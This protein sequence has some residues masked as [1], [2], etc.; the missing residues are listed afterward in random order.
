MLSSKLK[1]LILLLTAVFTLFVSTYQLAHAHTRLEIGPYILI[2][3]WLEEPV[4]VGERNAIIVDVTRNDIPVDDVE[5]TLDLELLYAGNSFRANLNPTDT[6]GVYTAQ[7]YPTVRGQYSVRLFGDI[8]GFEIDEI[9][10][11]EEVFPASRIQF[12]EAEPDS[13]EMETRLELLEANVRTAR[14]T[15]FVGVAVGLIGTVL[16][17]LGVRKK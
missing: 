17:V 9:V 8:D 14:L 10:D 4:I 11:P 7:V 16:G 3:G 15:S 1:T 2:I 12:P 5:A 6:V 13:F